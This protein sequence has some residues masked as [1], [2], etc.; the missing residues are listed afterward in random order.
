MKPALVDRTLLVAI[1][2]AV[3]LYCASLV[4]AWSW[5][6]DTSGATMLMVLGSLLL[7]ASGAVR[8]V[9][10][11]VRAMQIF[12]IAPRS[13]LADTIRW[14]LVGDVK[15]V[16]VSGKLKAHL[17]AGMT[18]FAAL[19]GLASTG[20][21]FGA[22][23]LLEFLG[24]KFL[25]TATTWELLRLLVCVGGMVPVS[26]GAAAV[27]G[28][29]ARIYGA[30]GRAGCAGYW[31]DW[32]W[33]AA[34]GLAA[35]G[36]LISAGLNLVVVFAAATVSLGVIAARLWRHKIASVRTARR[37]G[38][39]DELPLAMRAAIFGSYAA[40]AAALYV[41][42]RLLV[43][44]AAAPLPVTVCWTAAALAMLGWFAGKGDSARTTAQ[45]RAVYVAMIGIAVGLTM[46]FALSCAALA[47]GAAALLAGLCAAGA[48]VPVAWLAGVV[49][50]AQLHQFASTGA[51]MRT[52]AGTA[53]AG[54]A[55]GLLAVL[56]L[57][58]IG[59]VRLG[60]VV[61][62]V[63]VLVGG[64]VGVA[65]TVRSARGRR[66]WKACG[67]ML[68]LLLFVPVCVDLCFLHGRSAPAASGTWLSMRTA[69]GSPRSVRC[70]GGY[71]PA[72]PGRRSDAVTEAM[73]R[74]LARPA[75]QGRWW[76]VA[77]SDM[78]VP[79]SLPPTILGF[80]S[81]PDPSGVGADIMNPVRP[82]SDADFLRA[83]Q[84]EAHR[85]PFDGVLLAPLPADHP[86]AWRCY[87]TTTLTRTVNRAHR[88]ALIL[89][90]TQAA[91]HRIADALSVAKTFE[92][93]V[94]SGYLIADVSQD[95][96]DILLAG[97]A[98]SLSPPRSSPRL[99]AI[100]LS[101]LWADPIR[102]DT[103]HITRPRSSR[104]AQIDPWDLLSR[105]RVA[106]N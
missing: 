7:A 96:V 10:G 44:V 102:A 12:R 90:R 38:P 29:A 49:F 104:P 86:Q 105:A 70:L 6:F 50:S 87:N 106:G 79:A 46:Q 16:R 27:F 48:Q 22:S 58:R 93:V 40:L 14:A 59:A 100:D 26:L 51:P 4:M 17:L 103:I 63:A 53:A 98:D 74:I 88:G 62:V 64:I 31:R 54:L 72:R 60:L 5:A 41:Q 13:K 82:G 19:C 73:Q 2:A 66:R 45:R 56:L 68:L 78:D 99:I 71:L 9:H 65:S 81:F 47:G 61:A 91:A 3:V 83:A 1:A 23:V 43:D 39:P 76:I 30:S 95:G 34:G 84:S 11:A 24:D 92:A 85:E 36:L 89:L 42:C 57:G 25:W 8:F 69:P 77:G 55:G 52:Y 15:G 75:H 28:A 37:K 33:G 94:G 21:V 97:P 80:R 32:L 18:I 35:F 20:L 101:R 67:A